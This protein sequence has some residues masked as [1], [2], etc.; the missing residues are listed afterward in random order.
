M[1]IKFDTLDELKAFCANFQ[2]TGPG[3]EPAEVPKKRGR[4]PGSK[5][6]TIRSATVD[7]LEA[8]KTA[9]PQT[10]APRKRG[11]KPKSQASLEMLTA[12]VPKKRGRKPGSVN[13]VKEVGTGKRGRKSALA[14]ES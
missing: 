13:K 9:A 14:T 4:K 10:D 11:R 8:P 2:L 6:K 3:V 5:N 12:G 7:T 1:A